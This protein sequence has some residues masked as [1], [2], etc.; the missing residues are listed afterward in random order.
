MRRE[1]KSC[2]IG[3]YIIAIAKT[4]NSEFVQKKTFCLKACNL[5]KKILAN[6]KQTS[7]KRRIG[8]AN[9]NRKKKLTN[10]ILKVSMRTMSS[11]YF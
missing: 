10:V 6:L 8:E 11:S 2:V 3:G 1:K 4:R 7:K 9:E 5:A